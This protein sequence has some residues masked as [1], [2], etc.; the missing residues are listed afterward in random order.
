MIHL[1][2]NKFGIAPLD[3]SSENNKRNIVVPL[4]EI[5]QKISG[6]TDNW[7]S[8]S[9]MR[10]VKMYS[11]EDRNMPSSY[12]KLFVVSDFLNC[13]DDWKLLLCFILDVVSGKLFLIQVHLYLVH[14]LTELQPRQIP[15]LQKGTDI[16]GVVNFER[17]LD[18]KIALQQTSIISAVDPDKK[19]AFLRFYG[20]LENYLHKPY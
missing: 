7:F 5:M 18:G 9:I 20:E 2:V 12:L 8:P 19:R 15:D 10:E 4:L 6:A 13:Y 3:T 11:A 17:S 16:F 1:K 14:T